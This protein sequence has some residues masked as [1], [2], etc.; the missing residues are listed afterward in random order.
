MQP[1]GIAT[2]RPLKGFRVMFGRRTG[3]VTP[4]R[5]GTHF[6][7]QLGM[8]A[9]QGGMLLVA[10][11]LPTMFLCGVLHSPNSH[12]GLSEC[13]LLLVRLVWLCVRLMNQPPACMS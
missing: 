5:T 7:A 10:C 9:A 8:Y 3:L 4:K 12:T 11:T 6:A 2:C 13:A 1:S